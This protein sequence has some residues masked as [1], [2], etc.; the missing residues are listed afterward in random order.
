MRGHPKYKVGEF[1]KQFTVFVLC[2]PTEVPPI[3]LTIASEE[4]PAAH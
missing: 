3:W 2:G 4:R 1:L